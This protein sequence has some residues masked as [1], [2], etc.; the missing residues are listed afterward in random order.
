MD[1]IVLNRMEENLPVEVELTNGHLVVASY[2]RHVKDRIGDT[3][4]HLGIVH[5]I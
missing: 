2:K 5:H 4:F 1:F 3:K